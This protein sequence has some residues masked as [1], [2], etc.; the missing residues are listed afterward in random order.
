MKYLGVDFGLKRIGLAVS[1]GELASAWK[2]VEVKNLKDAIQKISDIV[3]LEN[4]QKIV[5]GLPEGKMGQT[6]R[7]FINKLKT[8][9]MEV[10]AADETLSSQIATKQ[11]IELNIPQR[12][13][14]TNDAYSASIILQKYLDEKI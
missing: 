2:V 10:V 14:K 12:K 8:S 5:V 7:G 6:V 13:R 9:G 3:K 1:E 4:F 11:M